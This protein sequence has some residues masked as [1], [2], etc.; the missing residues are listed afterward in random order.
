LLRRSCGK[1]LSKAAI[2]ARRLTKAEKINK[3]LQMSVEK[4]THP[5]FPLWVHLA[6]FFPFHGRQSETNCPTLVAVSAAA[7]RA[8]TLF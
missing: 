6:L 5:P 2:I 3:K 1:F 4:Y 8:L 7:F